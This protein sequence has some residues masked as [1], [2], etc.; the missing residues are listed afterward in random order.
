L[1]DFVHTLAMCN[2]AGRTSPQRKKAFGAPPA[3][4]V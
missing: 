4:Q 1:D 3:V 2:A